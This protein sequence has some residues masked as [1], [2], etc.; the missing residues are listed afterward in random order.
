MTRKLFFSLLTLL[1]AIFTHASASA[2]PWEDQVKRLAR[3][4]SVLVLDQADRPLFSLNPDKPLVPASIMKVVTSAA[5]LDL[6]GPD[7]RF[8]TDFKLAST[9]DLWILG[10]GD[11]FLVSEEIEAAVLEL[12]S[13]GLR[14]IRDLVLDNSYFTPDLVLDGTDRSLNPYDAFNGALCVNFNTISVVIDPAG[15]VS[16]AEPQTP[17]TDMARDLAVKTGAKGQVRFN[18]S[19]HPQTCLLY[20]GDLILTVLKKNGVKVGGRVR[21]TTGGAEN[22][23]LFYRRKSSRDLRWLLSR[24]LKFSNNFMANQIFLAWGAE[25]YGPPASEEKSRQALQAFLAE[26]EVPPFYVE[27]GS[28]LSRLTAMS[29]SQMIKV[30]KIFFPNRDLL[31]KEGSIF[32]KTGTMNGVRTIAGYMGEFPARGRLFVIMLNGAGAGNGVREKIL[33]L[34]EKNLN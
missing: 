30:L 26:K 7:Y 34:L 27:E 29:A 15:R 8:T 12:Q 14:E 20:A 18:L 10:R 28:G 21:S 23:P 32:F 31:T 24:T 19:D 33:D 22:I 3:D 9:G 1:L 4:G 17:L 13:Q 5:A 2:A 25:I 11:P 6:L 16:A